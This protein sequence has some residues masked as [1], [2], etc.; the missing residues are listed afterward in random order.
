MMPNDEF[1]EWLYQDEPELVATIVADIE[2]HVSKL[3]S[4]GETFYGYAVLPGEYSTMPDPATLAV[5]FNRESDIAPKN[6][7][8]VY[9]RYSVDAW[10]NYVREGFENSTSKLKSLLERFASMHSKDADDFYLDEYELAFVAKIHRA[11]LDALLKLKRSGLFG[12][13]TFLIIWYGDSDDEIMHESARALNKAEVYN[14]YA[15]EFQ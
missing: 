10:R 11:I 13:D 9:Y 1:W 7:N 14:E 5:A 12:S 15:A 8:S 3:R 6:V 4:A 2:R